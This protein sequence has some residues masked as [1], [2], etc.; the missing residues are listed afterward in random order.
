MARITTTEKTQIDKLWRAYLAKKRS[1]LKRGVAAN[2]IPEIVKPSADMARSLVNS[3]K[4]QL[5]SF[6]NRFNLNYQFQRIASGDYVPKT[7]VSALKTEQRRANAT[8]AKQ[9]RRN[10]DKPYIP[11]SERGWSHPG[12]HRTVESDAQKR[13]PRGYRKKASEF[14][15][16]AE[17]E[18]YIAHLKEFN[19]K[20][21]ADWDEMWRDN[22]IKAIL[23]VYGDAAK[24]LIDKIKAMDLN[25]F[26]SLMETQDISIS[27]VY[28]S[29]YENEGLEKLKSYFDQ[30]EYL[31]AYKTRRRQ[32]KDV[33][34]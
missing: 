9:Y 12:A 26:V 20:S 19:A 18:R 30:D 34:V 10:L 1:L 7:L 6:T 8:T 5:A 14:K 27:Y 25:T 16:Q 17:I 15:S 13:K 33:G 24:E 29:T 28:T 21:L 32:L 2:F 22:T 31:K 3:L 11:L 4:S 23:D